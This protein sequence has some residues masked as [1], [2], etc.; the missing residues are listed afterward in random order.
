MKNSKAI[1]HEENGF[2]L[3]VTMLIL[4]VLTLIG[5]SA[6]RNT[7]I[8]LQIAG[9]EKW[10]QEGFY[11]ADGATQTTVVIIEESIFNGGIDQNNYWNTFVNNLNFY[12]KEPEELYIGGIVPVLPTPPSTGLD[13][14]LA[15]NPA[16]NGVDIYM[17]R[18]SGAITKPYSQ[19]KAAGV[20]QLTPGAALH[21][22][23]G[24]EGVGQSAGQGG[25]Q[26]VY[27]IWANHFG[28]SNSEALLRVQWRHVN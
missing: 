9:N 21:M 8:E 12:M 7:S 26:V 17:P 23:S 5:I 11:K 4:V 18:S 2:V 1:L 28:Q 25:G 19:M 10:S 14:S 13:W 15:G 20:S 3:V 16:G 27:D 24:Y 22:A 6:T